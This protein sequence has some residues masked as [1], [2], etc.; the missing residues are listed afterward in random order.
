MHVLSY[1][2]WLIAEGVYLVDILLLF[3]TLMLIQPG[4]DALGPRRGHQSSQVREQGLR[5]PRPGP[6]VH[7]LLARSPCCIHS[8]KYE[9]PN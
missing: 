7:L 9:M 1:I 3:I 6:A 8:S 4:W 5:Q 2:C